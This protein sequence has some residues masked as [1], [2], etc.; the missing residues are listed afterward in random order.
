MNEVNATSK[1]IDLITPELIDSIKYLRT[2]EL[3]KV[4]KESGV[5]KSLFTA[6]DI[7]SQIDTDDIEGKQ[8]FFLPRL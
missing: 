6:E 2:L 8:H 4:P 1:E 7:F 3:T 5:D